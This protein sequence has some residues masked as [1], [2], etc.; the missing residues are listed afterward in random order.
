MNSIT[1]TG[2]D[3]IL[4]QY[5]VFNNTTVGNM[6]GGGVTHG[7]YSTIGIENHLGNVGLQYTFNNQ[8]P[9]AAMPL[10]NETALFITTRQPTSLL[11]GDVN[12]DGELNILDIIL[13]VNDVINIETLGP[14]EQYIADMNEDS[15]VN[16]LD[17]I[18]IINDILAQ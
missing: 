7:D 15:I 12:M 16:V 13:V 5:K 3:E 6:E 10:Q 4:I 18:L 11:K 17:V 8:Y 1:P 9:V 14:L 2:D